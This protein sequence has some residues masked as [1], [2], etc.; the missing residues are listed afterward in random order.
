MFFS[1]KNKK[2]DIHLENISRYQEAIE[3]IRYYIAVEEWENAT[4]GI[5][6]IKIKENSAYKDLLE[7]ID[8]DGKF[9][10]NEKNKT[11]QSYQKRV[12]KINQLEQLLNK[13][14]HIFK[15]KEEK[16]RFKIRFKK[17]KIELDTL[18]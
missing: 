7:K 5:Q 15:E 12:Q 11:I 16:E 14:E 6:E 1:K 18:L 4:N 8:N 9:N 2:H 10:E 3:V 13:K 17:I